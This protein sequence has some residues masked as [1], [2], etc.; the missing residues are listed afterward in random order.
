[1][2]AAV[3]TR[4]PAVVRTRTLGAAGLLALFVAVSSTLRFLALA[5][6]LPTPFYLPDEY[7]Y[8]ALA[9]GLAE[10]GRPVI[11]GEPAHFPALLEPVL[12]A[13]FW[14]FGDAQLALRLTQAE[15]AIIMSLGAI[16]VY[17]ICRRVGLDVRLALGAALLALVSPDL[18]FSSLVVADP[19]AYPLVLAAIYAAIAAL[20]SPSRRAQCAVCGWVCLAAFAR[21]QYVLLIPVFV[22]AAFVVE[23]G[24]VRQFQK[25]FGLATALFA[26]LAVA[27]IAT[28]PQ[29]LLG[30]YQAVFHLRA[31]LHTVVS[32]VGIHALL[33]PFAAGVVLVPGALIG[34]SRALLRPAARVERA[35]AAITTL[36]AF[37]LFAQAVFVASTISGN[38][39][40]RYLF[41]F[42]P[43]L[44]PAFVIYARRGG[45]LGW[46]V[47][48]S[49]AIAL[50]AMRFPLSHYVGKSSD[51]PLLW[52]VLQLESLLGVANGALVIS[53][54]AVLL[55]A[56]AVWVAL[57][58]RHRLAAALT[59]AI[60]SQ[61]ALAAAA[62]AWGTHI[63]RLDRRALPADARWL[64]HARVGPVTLVGTP[65]NDT[66]AGIEQLIWNRSIGSIVLL[67][68]A[69]LVDSHDNF[70]VR[71]AA[72]GSLDATTGPVRGALLVDRAR[73]WT[74]FSG[75]RLVR[76][77]AGAS[78]APFDLWVPTRSTSGP[79][80]VAEVAGLMS[81]GWLMRTGW[82]T[83]WPANVARRFTLEVTLPDARAATDTIHFSGN[84]VA[85]SFS[86]GP[87]Q[88]RRISFVV[89]AGARPWT[90]TWSCDR[91]A[92]RGRWPVSFTATTPTVVALP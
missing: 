92:Y 22:V 84:G 47:G 83:V 4:L 87:Q 44:V 41:F 72:D 82:V 71:V 39:G 55:A 51:S 54:G 75:A 58:P 29:R 61:A 19:I 30:T 6:R 28:G 15:H 18:V 70:A 1:M 7:T 91:Y 2:D 45:S 10:T 63:S 81:D 77:T 65:G 34:L 59:I 73:T 32:Q 43:L 9:R 68:R 20:D 46:I 48:I 21:V 53:A 26:A 56:F 40:E 60:V 37:G 69:A 14:L 52:G 33:L 8:S 50:L 42:I 90:L 49:L 66:G 85:K 89:P 11:R 31:P 88:T 3:V 35:Y 24:S 62:S 27:A 64:D 16:P 67:P 5:L 23:R 36:F 12:A 25:S 86:I 80:L 74:S 17:L 57:R 38:F 79:R 13:P 78:G 76:S